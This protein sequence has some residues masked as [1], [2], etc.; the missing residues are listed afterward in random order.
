VVPSEFREAAGPRRA[1]DSCSVAL[2]VFSPHR[3]THLDLGLLLLLS[4]FRALLPRPTDLAGI[5]AKTAAVCA[6]LLA[7]C[8]HVLWARPNLR[9]T[10]GW[11]GCGAAAAAGLVGV[12]LL[13][14]TAL[15]RDAGLGGRALG[16]SDRRRRIC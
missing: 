16:P 14:A 3:P 12:T 1:S 11:A 13:G 7:S 10:R 8:P 9:R 4:L 6:A 15:A 2:G 5:A